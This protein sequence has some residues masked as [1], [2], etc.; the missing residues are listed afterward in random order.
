MSN[1]AKEVIKC[2]QKGITKNE[3]IRE[4]IIR[5]TGKTYTINS[6]SSIK[7]TLK[8]ARQVAITSN[9]TSTNS[10]DSTVLVNSD[11]IDSQK[12]QEMESETQTQ[13]ETETETTTIKQ[14][15]QPKESRSPLGNQGFIKGNQKF[16]LQGNQLAI[17]SEASEMSQ[18]YKEDYTKEVEDPD[19]IKT[20]IDVKR[21]ADLSGDALQALYKTEKMKEVTKGYVPSDTDVE[22]INKDMKSMIEIRLG[23]DDLKSEFG[24]VVNALTGI[25]LVITKGF[26]HRLRPSK[27]K[28]QLVELVN[29]KEKEIKENFEEI[30]KELKKEEKPKPKKLENKSMLCNDCNE[31]PIY[32]N[33]LCD[34]CFYSQML[35]TNAQ[36]NK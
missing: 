28:D 35:Q 12:N 10:S 8:S 26:I 21:F 6:I 23:A 34:Q 1:L 15:P 20:P 22:M 5:E 16:I 4:E 29:K 14:I 36:E 18:A 19:I 25:V 2:L 17:N 33:G 9:S 7:S 24:D 11:N 30:E 13:T 32:E 27:K 3:K 31:N